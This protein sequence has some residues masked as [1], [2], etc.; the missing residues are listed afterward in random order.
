[1]VDTFK[2]GD[3]VT[4]ADGQPFAGNVNGFVKRVIH[5]KGKITVIV[6]WGS[7]KGESFRPGNLKMVVRS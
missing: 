5:R 4:P 7:G 2:C 3:I 6:D 1:M